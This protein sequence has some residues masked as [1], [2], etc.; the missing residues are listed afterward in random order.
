ML[1]Y[2]HN[3]WVL[4]DDAFSLAEWVIGSPGIHSSPVRFPAQIIHYLLQHYKNF[5]THVFS[6]KLLCCS[7]T[8]NQLSK[9]VLKFFHS[10]W[11][12]CRK[13]F[14]NFVEMLKL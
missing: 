10:G 11:K 1:Q 4:E 14:S 12:G 9:N 7:V 6:V 5:P 2:L 13:I 8:L 3:V